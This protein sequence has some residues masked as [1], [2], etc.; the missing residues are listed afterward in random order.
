MLI[1]AGSFPALCTGSMKKD[2]QITEPTKI[3][4]S[5][6]II[7]PNGD[8]ISPNA[9]SKEGTP[10][11]SDSKEGAKFDTIKGEINTFKKEEKELKMETTLIILK[12]DCME[13]GLSGEVIGRFCKEKFEIVGCKMISL[14]ETLLREH[15]A[16]IAN[17]PFFPEILTFMQ[18]KPVIVLALR[19]EGVIAKVRDLLGPT[20]SALAPKGTIRGDWGTDKMRN[21]AH[22]SDS[23]DSAQKELGRFF[24]S[25]ELFLK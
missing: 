12:P 21:I 10:G 15:Y 25:A 13:K 11:S 7:T 4:E 6:R 16:H 14:P 18:S 3:A 20:D 22:A 24:T 8:T 9:A 5:N 1:F 17:L 19:G 23:K 2:S